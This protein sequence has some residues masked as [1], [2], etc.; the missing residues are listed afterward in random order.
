[1]SVSVRRRVLG[2]DKRIHIPFRRCRTE[3]FRRRK[4]SEDEKMIQLYTKT[5]FCPDFDNY[6]DIVE[7]VNL[8]NDQ[9]RRHSFSVEIYPCDPAI[10]K[11]C[12]GYEKADRLYQEFHVT[13]STV[14]DRIDY[15]TSVQQDSKRKEPFKTSLQFH[16]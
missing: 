16:S 13:L 3:D 14:I 15:S 12:V 4:V 2:K 7:V 10:R 11:T 9:E 6:P 8:Y 1:M 5:Q